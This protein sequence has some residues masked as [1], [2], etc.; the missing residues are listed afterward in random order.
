MHG[1]GIYFKDGVTFKEEMF[2]G[3]ESGFCIVEL[4]ESIIEGIKI[5]DEWHGMYVET[6]K[7]TNYKKSLLAEN[8]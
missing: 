2:Q 1:V 7:K 8:G 3:I 4:E 5:N 6:L